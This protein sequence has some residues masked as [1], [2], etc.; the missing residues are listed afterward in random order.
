MKNL[1]LSV[2]AISVV[3]F[4]HSHAVNATIPTFDPSRYEAVFGDPQVFLDNFDAELTPRLN[5]YMGLGISVSGFILV[6]RSL[7]H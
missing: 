5:E 4:S 7:M 6:I 3:V 1:L 2:F